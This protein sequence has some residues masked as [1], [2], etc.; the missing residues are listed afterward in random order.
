MEFTN[1]LAQNCVN[2]PAKKELLEEI[3]TQQIGKSVEVELV[4]KK[5]ETHQNLAEISVD[6]ILKQAVH[7]DI[8]VEDEPDDEL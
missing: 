7:M 5:G 8:V 2:D 4:L 3:I 1:D 6:D